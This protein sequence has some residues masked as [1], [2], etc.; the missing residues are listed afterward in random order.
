MNR[1]SLPRAI[2]LPQAILS[3]IAIWEARFRLYPYILRTP[4][5]YSQDLSTRFGATIYLKMECWQ[6][7]GSF[8]IRGL[9]NRV[10]SLPSERRESGLVASSCGNQGIALAFVGNLFHLPVTIFLP[11]EADPEKV[12]SIQALGGETIVTGESLPDAFEKAQS[13][14][15]RTGR[16][17]IYHDHLAVMAG[18]GTI[19]LEILEDLPD[20]ERI[21]VPI[22]AGGLCSGI[23]TAIK[24]GSSSCSIIGVEPANAPGAYL[25]LQ[26]GRCLERIATK[27]SLADGLLGGPSPVTFQLLSQFLEQ[28]VLAE[29]EEILQAMSLLQKSEQILVEGSGAVGL[30]ALVSGKVKITEKKTVLVI[31]GRNI[32]Q[33]QWNQVMTPLPSELDSLK[34]G[35]A[36]Q[37]N[38]A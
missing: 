18:H 34:T 7:C 19:G 32:S 26:E 12:T 25:S 31:T 36:L 16:T 13:F 35:V 15:A 5:M 3:P 28:V 22:G 23:A 6:H 27:P 9:L 1:F 37:K 29:E 30:A 4:L 24:S 8:K 10:L 38:H 2:K 21:L 33:K 20:V 11:T 14:A 17:L